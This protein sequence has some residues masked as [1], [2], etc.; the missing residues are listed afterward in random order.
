MSHCTRRKSQTATQPENVA[1]QP[2]RSVYSVYAEISDNDNQMDDMT[3]KQLKVEPYERL[4]RS[5]MNTEF[6]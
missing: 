1:P 2:P 3:Y 4:N 6:M 5:A